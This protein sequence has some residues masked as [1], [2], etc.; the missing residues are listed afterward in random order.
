MNP[1]WLMGIILASLVF[2]LWSGFVEGTYISAN[3]TSTMNK[4]MNLQTLTWADPANVAISSFVVGSTI[5]EALWKMFWWDYAQF[6]GDLI[7]F[8]YVGIAVSIGI[9][10]TIALSIINRK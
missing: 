8:R 6:N 7:V 1:K 9:A 10:F 3:T 4:L 5:I 2:S